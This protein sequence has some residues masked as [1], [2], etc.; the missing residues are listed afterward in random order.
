MLTIYG[1]YR[2]RASRPLWLLAELGLPFRHVPV[3][4]AYRLSDATGP[5]APLNTASPEFLKVNPL[6]QIPCMDADGLVLTESLAITL[7]IA[8][9]HG[10]LFGPQTPAEG[11][12][13][14][15]WAL[16]AATSLEGPSLEIL[17]IQQDGGDATREGQAGLAIAAQ[18]LRRPLKRLEDHL[19]AHDYLM[20]DRFTVADINTAEC[21]RY[22]QGHAALMEEHPKVKAWLERCQSRPGFQSMMQKRLEEPA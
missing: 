13:M 10:G 21:L 2:S 4:Q 11:A 22:A 16:F 15:Q 17:F 20:G 8:R 9:N 6:G 5:D 3:I 7:Y 12:L 18:K 1:V 14:T 19:A